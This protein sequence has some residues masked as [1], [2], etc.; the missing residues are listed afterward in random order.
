MPGGVA[1]ERPIRAAPYAD[2]P[3]FGPRLHFRGLPR[4]LGTTANRNEKALAPSL[5]R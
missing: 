3:Q 4:N 5:T 1:G 2:Y